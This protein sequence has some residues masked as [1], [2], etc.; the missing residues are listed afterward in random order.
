MI[1]SKHNKSVYKKI[2]LSYK[3]QFDQLKKRGLKFHD[4]I[5]TLHLLETLS[6]YR[7]SGYLYPLLD[8]PKSKH[9]FKKDS[10]FEDAF[11]MYCFDRD[12]RTLLFR[13][14]DKIEIAFKAKLIYVLSH[15][16]GPFWFENETN[17]KNSSIHQKSLSNIKKEVQRS[18]TDFIIKFNENYSNIYPPSWMTIEVCS[19]GIVSRLYSGLKAGRSK[20]AI[21]NH[22]GLTEKTMV[23]WLHSLVYLRNICAHHSRLWNRN[24]QINPEVPKLFKPN[25][26]RHKYPLNRWVETKEINNNRTYFSICVIKY[27]LD[28][29][30]PEN[31]LKEYFIN[32]FQK[33]PS[34]NP[35]ALD[36]P[37]NWHD[38]SFWNN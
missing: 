28:T 14:L 15:E 1:S 37:K 32:L 16:H 23:S 2:A 19:F 26:N 29:I 8:A 33:Y 18:D 4:S 11:D 13:Q 22:F 35:S 9:Y 6:Y 3:D 27:F 25:G 12:L 24:L 20:R 34:I 17:F 7:I 5:K 21:A 38:Q 36:F 10:Y 31:K 30:D